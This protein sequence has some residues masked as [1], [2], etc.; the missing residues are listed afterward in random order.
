MSDPDLSRRVEKLETVVEPLPALVQKIHGN[1]NTL[2][3]H[4]GQLNDILGPKGSM[5]MRLGKVEG[6]IELFDERLKRIDEGVDGLRGSVSR[7]ID[8]SEVQRDAI[9]KLTESSEVAKANVAGQWQ[10][11]ATM[12]TAALAGLSAT[13]VAAMQFL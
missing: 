2:Q 11:R 3:V 6:A 4:A 1:A 5:L 7:L 9:Y 13:A 12:F 8:A 10:M